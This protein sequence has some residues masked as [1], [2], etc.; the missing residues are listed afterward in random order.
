M[1]ENVSQDHIWEGSLG[2]LGCKWTVESFIAGSTC[3]RLIWAGHHSQCHI[4]EVNQM[5]TQGPP[6]S[7]IHREG[8]NKQTHKWVKSGA[9]ERMT[10][11]GR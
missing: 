11:G 1:Q 5:W 7:D 4:H 3:Q 6:D 9:M 8:D 2:R 10:E